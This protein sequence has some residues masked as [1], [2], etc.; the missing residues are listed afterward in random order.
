MSVDVCSRTAQILT[1]KA[2]EE[3]D[4][5]STNTRICYPFRRI[6]EYA[7]RHVRLTQA[8][9]LRRRQEPSDK[10]TEEHAFVAEDN[11]SQNRVGLRSVEARARGS[12]LPPLSFSLQFSKEKKGRKKG[13][14]GKKVRERKKCDRGWGEK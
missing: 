10:K 14:G 9:Q 8:A 5:L 1:H 2:K 3:F 11:L 4:I 13:E 6:H 7:E 12:F